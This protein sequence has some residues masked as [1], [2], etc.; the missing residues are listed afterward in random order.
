VENG[1]TI[2]GKS[3]LS[4]TIENET[5]KQ[6]SCAFAKFW[7]AYPNKIAKA[8][9]EAIWKRFMLDDE[10]DT[11]LVGLKRWSGCEQWQNPRFIPHPSTF[12][13][14]ERWKAVPPAGEPKKG[15]MRLREMSPKHEAKARQE[16]R[17]PG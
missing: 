14:K 15:E 2:D 16:S 1:P 3:A 12:L 8:K 6:T 17:F 7:E 10:A 13:D 4:R 9:C 5:E 11:V